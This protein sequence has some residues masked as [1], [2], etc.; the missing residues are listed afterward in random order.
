MSKTEIRFSKTVEN[1]YWDGWLH[2]QGYL[3]TNNQKFDKFVREMEEMI[4]NYLSE[5]LPKWEFQEVDPE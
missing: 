4:G 2:A 3:N 5:E 1:M